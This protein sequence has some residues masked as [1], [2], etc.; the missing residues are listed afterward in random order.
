M[1]LRI[2]KF[3]IGLLL[4]PLG[5]AATW[6]VVDL[7][8]SVN[9]ASGAELGPGA[10]WLAGGFMFWL[11]LYTVMPRP[12]RS[13]VLAHELTHALWAWAMGSRV[14]GIRVGSEGGYVEVD[15]VNVWITL[16]PYFFP[17][18]TA[19]VLLV[20]GGLSMFYDLSVYEPFWLALV[21]L[22]WSFHLTFTLST[23]RTH[24]PDIQAHG[25][26][27][28][29]TLIYL[30][31]LLGVGLWIVAAGSPQ[32]GDFAAQLGGHLADMTAGCGAGISRIVSRLFSA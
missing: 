29:Y 20:H 10:W 24:Q 26:L 6:A 19:L 32:L 23:L 21:G 27:F 11:V 30:L 14:S 31:N 7:L 9:L 16:A 3:L 18:Y 17:L 12:V 5:V 25:R 13:Y 8:R 28:S 2:I 1:L 15:R 22:T 4:L